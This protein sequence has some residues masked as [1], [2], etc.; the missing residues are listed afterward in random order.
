M[1][2]TNIDG[3]PS[4]TVAY[5]IRYGKTRYVLDAS[6]G[7][8]VLKR[9]RALLHDGSHDVIPLTHRDGFTWLVVGPGIPLTIEEVSP[10]KGQSARSALKHLG[11]A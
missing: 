11:L 10:G 3:L 9:I 7:T 1:T 2:N 8:D 6:E 4:T 5:V